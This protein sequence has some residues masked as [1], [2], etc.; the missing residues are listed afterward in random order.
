MPAAPA[1][2]WTSYTWAEAHFFFFF[3]FLRGDPEQVRENPTWHKECITE[4]ISRVSFL[5]RLLSLK[6]LPIFVEVNSFPILLPGTASSQSLSSAFQ[7]WEPFTAADT[8]R[9]V[10]HLHLLI[11]IVLHING[12]LGPP[13]Q[14]NSSGAIL[15][16]QNLF[17]A[18]AL[19]SAVL[20][21]IFFSSFRKTKY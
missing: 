6:L 15:S 10:N 20:M 16:I 3:F 1:G 8:F 19:V 13:P 11:C 4:F 12:C 9:L 14:G 5:P 17:L 21:T 18:M 7:S 2:L